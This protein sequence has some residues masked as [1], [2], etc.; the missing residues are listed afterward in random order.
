MVLSIKHDNEED[1][2]GENDEDN[3]YV[4]D[5]DEVPS[6]EEDAPLS[7]PSLDEDDATP[8]EIRIGG[9]VQDELSKYSKNSYTL[10]IN[11]H[12]A[13]NIFASIYALKTT[14]IKRPPV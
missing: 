5:T 1:E 8:A 12:F 13:S 3:N 7:C 10:F 14:C 4:A 9:N 2:E 11:H 6:S